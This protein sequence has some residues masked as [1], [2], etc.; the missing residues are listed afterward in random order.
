MATPRSSDSA[1]AS[2]AVRTPEPTARPGPRR[3]PRRSPGAESPRPRSCASLLEQ[4]ATDLQR[5]QW[6]ALR[7]V[8]DRRN[9]GRETVRP[10]RSHSIRRSAPSVMAPSSTLTTDPC[11]SARSSSGHTG[12]APREQEA[13]AEVPKRRAA[14][15]R[16]SAEERSSHC[17]SST[18]ITS[19]VRA[20]RTRTAATK[21]NATAPAWTEPSIGSAPQKRR[22][23][24]P[25]LRG[26][27]RRELTGPHV[28]TQ[29]D[30]PGER[31]PRLALARPRLPAPRAL[32]ARRADPASQSVVLPIPASPTSTRPRTPPSSTASPRRTQAHPRARQSTPPKPPP[33]PL[34]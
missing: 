34:P 1:V 9:S 15:V 2:S 11:S 6:I 7:H 25:P 10:R 12:R 16:T 31:Q 3:S 20:A 27:Q 30:Q 17:K 8:D 26:R 19:G 13:D 5:E 4:R 33:P 21:P 23:K 28:L 29:V 18:A 32:V 14:N 24:C 22:L